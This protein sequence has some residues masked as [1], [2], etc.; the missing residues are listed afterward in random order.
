MSDEQR[1][2]HYQ[3]QEGEWQ[4]DHRMGGP[5]RRGRA[6]PSAAH[7]Q[8]TQFRRRIDREVYERDHKEAI[9]EALEDFSEDHG[10]QL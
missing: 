2:G 6:E 1:A 5:D 7:E 10:G 9:K 3:D 4:S 8:R